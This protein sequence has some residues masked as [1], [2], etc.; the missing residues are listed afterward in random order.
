[1]TSEKI[2]QE[3]LLEIRFDDS[4]D[5]S[6]IVGKLYDS[7]SSS[8]PEFENLNIPDFPDA[9]PDFNKIVRYR[10]YSN[11]RKLLYNLGKG[12]LSINTVNYTGFPNFLANVEKVIN[13]HIKISGTKNISRIGLRYI[14]KIDSKIADGG[15]S[16]NIKFMLPEELT[17]VQKGFAFQNIGKINSDILT[18]RF[19]T[20]NPLSMD[21]FILDFDYY[22][23]QNNEYSLKF[24]EKWI[25]KAHSEISQTFKGSVSS[26]FYKKLIA[27]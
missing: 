20:E 23:E 7:L 26:D 8:Y 25:A 17:K 14:N 19:L 27:K 15:K 22:T 12:V 21:N 3:V 9:I 1:M 16:F 10:F 6:L 18:T 5:L 24:I 11:D 2:L 4:K 13:E